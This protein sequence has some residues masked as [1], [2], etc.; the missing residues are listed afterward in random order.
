MATYNL[1]VRL[2][3]FQNVDAKNLKDAFKK[4]KESWKEMHDIELSDFDIKAYKE[5]GIR[6]EDKYG[7]PTIKNVPYR[8]FDEIKIEEET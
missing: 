6:Y 8:Q 2:E 5:V 1:G 7:Y 4:V 3:T